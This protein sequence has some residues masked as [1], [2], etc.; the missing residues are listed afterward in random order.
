MADFGEG[1]LPVHAIQA[2]FKQYQLIVQRDA[3]DGIVRHLKR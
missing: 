1:G 3:V 2:A